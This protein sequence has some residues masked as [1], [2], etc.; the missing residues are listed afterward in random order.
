MIIEMYLG[1][2]F[3]NHDTHIYIYVIVIDIDHMNLHIGQSDTMNLYMPINVTELKG[4]YD[5]LII[6][7]L[8]QIDSSFQIDF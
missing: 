7:S 8:V 1:H 3:I 5:P 2:I 6:I 4:F